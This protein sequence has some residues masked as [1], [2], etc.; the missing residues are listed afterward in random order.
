LNFAF[1]FVD[2]TSFDVVTMDPQTPASLFEDAAKAKIINPS[3]QVFLSIGGWTFS[4]NGTATQPVLGNICRSQ[5]N[6]NIFV[7]NLLKF[8]MSYGFD[9]MLLPRGLLA[10]EVY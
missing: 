1:A 9:G 4:D 10:K 7:K 6:R 8:L 2:P 3:I 5:T